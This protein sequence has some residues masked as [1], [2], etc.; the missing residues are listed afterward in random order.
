MR[1]ISIFSFVPIF[2]G[3]QPRASRLERQGEPY[4][5][6]PHETAPNGCRSIVGRGG[7]AKYGIK[8]ASALRAGE[9]SVASKQAR[10]AGLVSCSTT[11][12][13][14]SQHSAKSFCVRYLDSFLGKSARYRLEP[15]WYQREGEMSWQ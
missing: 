9:A 8:N 5:R 4:P 11:L 10:S 12:T 3:S 2:R 7:K 1:Q 14:C 13:S 6:C 15:E